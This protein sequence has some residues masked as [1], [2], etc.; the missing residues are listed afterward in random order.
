MSW[1]VRWPLDYQLCLLI[2]GIVAFKSGTRAISRLW[3]KTQKWLWNPFSEWRRG[4]RSCK[5]CPSIL[6]SDTR[7]TKVSLASLMSD[8]TGLFRNKLFER[9]VGEGW[10][11]ENWRWWWF[12]MGLEHRFLGWRYIKL[13]KEKMEWESWR[14]MLPPRMEQG[15]R[16]P[17]T[18]SVNHGSKAQEIRDYESEFSY[19]CK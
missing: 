6:L 2:F 10:E 18:D 1:S 16:L 13:K 4:W 3:C 7:P 15:V 9:Q 8:R 12:R 17:V 14:I 11:W 5:L 19:Y